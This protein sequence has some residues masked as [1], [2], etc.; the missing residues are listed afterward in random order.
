[1]ANELD[2]MTGPVNGAGR[3]I[4]VIE[5]QLPTCVGWGSTLFEILL[6]CLGIIPGLIFLFMKIGESVIAVTAHGYCGVERVDYENVHGGDGEWH[7]VAVPWVEYL[8]V[9]RTSEMCLSE[10]G[11]TSDLFGKRAIASGSGVYRRS[12]LSFLG[13][14]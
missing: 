14:A 9:Q 13:G 8:P 7:S 5:K 2:E 12:I 1:M 11:E 10:R 3:D 4:N 6:W